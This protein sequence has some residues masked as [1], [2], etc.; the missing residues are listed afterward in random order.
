MVKDST[1]LH[2]AGNPVNHRVSFWL[3]HDGTNQP[4]KMNCKKL[5]FLFLSFP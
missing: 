4:K 2:L 3:V 1:L 5:F